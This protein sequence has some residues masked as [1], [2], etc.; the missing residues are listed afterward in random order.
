MSK[1]K[2]SQYER[3]I[4]LMNT[5]VFSGDSG[6][7]YFMGKSRAFVLKNGMNNLYEPIRQDVLK[8]FAD[9]GIAWWRGSQPTGHTLSSQMA[10]L[11]HL[12][13]IR[14]DR[15][16]VLAI[17][18]GIRDEFEDVLPIPSDAEPSYIAFE[19]VSNEDHLNEGTSTRGTNCTSVDAF[20]YAKH[21]LD[22]KIWL[23]P[24]EWK[25]TES[26]ENQ[27]KS[28]EDRVNEPKGSNGKGN[29][30]LSRYTD[31]INVSTQLKSLPEYRSSVYYQEPFYQLMRQTLW[32]EN[33]LKNHKVEKL[34]ADD[35]LHVH[36]IPK[37]NHDLLNKTYKVSGKT[38]EETWRSML[39]DQSKYV[40]V[41]PQDLMKPIFDL[42]SELTEYLRL[43]YW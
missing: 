16:A 15:D 25:Y 39:S 26:Y 19:V 36:V 21:R 34:K 9:N 35:Y 31:L 30:R 38:M 17:L 27:D 32:A 24:I 7:G 23:I 29:E 40:I 2:E 33:I 18:N 14:N 3:Q 42:Y 12:F 11:N 1:F 41:D 28:S 8:Y 4:L 37:A 20:I 22:P 13:A 43:R 5:D 10:C 6:N